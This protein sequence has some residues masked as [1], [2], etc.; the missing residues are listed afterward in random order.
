MVPGMEP[1]LLLFPA[2]AVLPDLPDLPVVPSVCY[3]AICSKSY[4]QERKG[5]TGVWKGICSLPLGIFLFLHLVEFI[6][7]III[8]FFKRAAISA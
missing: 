8:L 1:S 3:P 2:L 6:G 4:S 7:K 5:N